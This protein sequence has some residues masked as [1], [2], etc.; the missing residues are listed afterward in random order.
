M[1][2]G[3]RHPNGKNMKQERNNQDDADLVPEYDL[4]GG[5]RGKYVDHFTGRDN[6]IFRRLVF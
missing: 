3:P 4:T 1:T 2:A 6:S 5:V